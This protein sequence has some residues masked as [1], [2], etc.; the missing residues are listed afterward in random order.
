MATGMTFPVLTMKGRVISLVR[1]EDR[2]HL[3]TK[4]ALRSGWF[5]GLKIVDFTGK[6][7]RVKSAEFSE[8]TNIKSYPGW[9]APRLV[10]VS[11]DIDQGRQLTTDELRDRALK[12]V[13]SDREFWASGGQLHSILDS[14]K[15]AATVEQIWQTLIAVV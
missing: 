9:F 14:L 13:N 6:E 7:F 8:K 3:A 5:H 1:D 12:A 4:H 2:L 10:R 11:L 15:A